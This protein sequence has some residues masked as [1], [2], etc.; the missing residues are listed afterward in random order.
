MSAARQTGLPAARAGG[1]QDDIRAGLAALQAQMQSMEVRMD[2]RFESLAELIDAKLSPVRDMA[3]EQRTIAH[4]HGR[5]LTQ[6][7]TVIDKEVAPAVKQTWR[8]R[9]E[10]QALQEHAKRCD[11]R[12]KTSGNRWWRVLELALTPAIA[13]AVG[14]FLGRK[15]G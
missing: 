11:E 10:V 14:W 9:D 13:A 1:D 7:E 8:T 3:S 6:I 2:E 5:R 4:D 12:S 15:G